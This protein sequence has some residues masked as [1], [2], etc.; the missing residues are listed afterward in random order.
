[1]SLRIKLLTKIIGKVL[2]LLLLLPMVATAQVATPSFS[3]VNTPVNPALLF[4]VEGSA[5]SYSAG[6]GLGLDD[7]GQVEAQPLNSGWVKWEVVPQTNGSI[8]F[9]HQ[10][11]DVTRVS[12]LNTNSLSWGRSNQN[13]KGALAY[14]ISQSQPTGQISYDFGGYGNILG[15]DFYL[16]GFVRNGGIFA[17]DTNDPYDEEYHVGIGGIHWDWFRW[18]WA[19][20][21]VFIGANH[22]I[23]TH[24]TLEFKIGNFVLGHSEIEYDDAGTIVAANQHLQRHQLSYEPE[25]SGLAVSAEMIMNP[26]NSAEEYGRFTTGWKF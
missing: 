2:G 23:S 9:S 14:E 26:N 5:M 10:Q 24:Q 15:E 20:S 18:E 1:M 13:G 21:H 17:K 12:G 22:R 16:G 19:N 4:A 6:A 3:S 11:G 8:N 7:L 25:G